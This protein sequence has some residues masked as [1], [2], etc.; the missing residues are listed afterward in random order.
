MPIEQLD[1]FTF[2]NLTVND[3]SQRKCLA[4]VKCSDLTKGTQFLLQCLASH[5]VEA[6]CDTYQPHERRSICQNCKHAKDEHPLT[7][8]DIKELRATLATLAEDSGA[9]PP[10]GDSVYEWIPLSAP[11]IALKIISI[12]F[13]L[14]R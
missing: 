8:K 7:E 6:V 9:E 11:K 10:R 13:Q 4:F 14:I 3:I 2:V 12:V 5:D 1:S